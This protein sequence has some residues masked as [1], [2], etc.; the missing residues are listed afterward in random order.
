M[1]YLDYRNDEDTVPDLIK[2]S[3]VSLPQPIAIMKAREFLRARRPRIDAELFNPLEDSFAVR[4]AVEA[5]DVLKADF[6]K[7]TL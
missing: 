5:A 2:D 3:K 6:V 4:V 7:T 1:A